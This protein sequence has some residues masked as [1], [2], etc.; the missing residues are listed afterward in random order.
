MLLIVC[1]ANVQ[2]FSTIV[3]MGVVWLRGR[4]K[5]ITVCV[6]RQQNTCITAPEITKKRH[7]GAE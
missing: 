5:A 4:R 1:G 7:G 2:C 3:M 6:R